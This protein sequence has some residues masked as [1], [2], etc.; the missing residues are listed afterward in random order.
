MTGKWG[1]GGEGTGEH[2]SG[3]VLKSGQYSSAVMQDFDGCQWLWCSRGRLF[4]EG[5]RATLFTIFV[6]GFVKTIITSFLKDDKQEKTA[7]HK[8]KHRCFCVTLIVDRGIMTKLLRIICFYTLV[9]GTNTSLYF[10]FSL[11]QRFI[12]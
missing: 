3:T 12:P 11:T 5:T 1:W 7:T 2:F 6:Y 10:L 4:K 9:K 8:H